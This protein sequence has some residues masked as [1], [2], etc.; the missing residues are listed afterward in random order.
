[1]PKKRMEINVCSLL[2]I[3]LVAHRGNC[4]NSDPP[5]DLSG[6]ILSQPDPVSSE[7]LLKAIIWETDGRIKHEIQ[8]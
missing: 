1:M 8:G 4:R 3:M 7:L 6:S 5:F 2:N